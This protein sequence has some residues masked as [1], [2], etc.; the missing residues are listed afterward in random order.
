[1]AYA[2][3]LLQLHQLVGPQDAIPGVVFDGADAG[4]DQICSA[5][6]GD[7]F[8]DIGILVQAVELLFAGSVQR[9]VQRKEAPAVHPCEA[10]AQ[11]NA[12]RVCVRIGHRAHD[13][14]HSHGDI[15]CGDHGGAYM[16]DCVAPGYADHRVVLYV[17]G[18]VER[19]H[20]TEQGQYALAVHAFG[21]LQHAHAGDGEHGLQF[22]FN[23]QIALPGFVDLQLYDAVLTR[24]FDQPRYCRAGQK[25][26]VCDLG[27][28][29]V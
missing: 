29:H 13:G 1:M 21:H 12:L 4:D 6:N 24:L 3:D 10:L 9:G 14:H 20:L 2:T 17:A 16:R 23:G 26:S 7:G 19:R 8:R 15:L 27:L 22:V 18:N 25:Q 11:F 5:G 28:T